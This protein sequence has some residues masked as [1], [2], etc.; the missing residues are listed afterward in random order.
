MNA[1]RIVL[2]VAIFAV[3]VKYLESISTIGGLSGPPLSDA[4]WDFTK[5]YVW[6][7]IITI[8]GIASLLPYGK[9]VARALWN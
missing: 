6:A 8:A 3:I 2:S 9:K 1:L 4:P 5:G 7:L